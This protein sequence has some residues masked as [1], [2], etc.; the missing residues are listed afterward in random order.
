MNNYRLALAVLILVALAA[1][2]VALAQNAGDAAIVAAI[3][4]IENDSTKADLANDRSYYEKY[5]AADWTSIDSDGLVYTKADVLKEFDDPANN[6]TNSEKIT[7]MKVRVYGGDTAIAIYKVTYD[8]LVKGEH[9]SRTV[10][11]TDVWVK[12]GSDWKLVAGQGTKIAGK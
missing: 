2:S 1:G 9:R 7:D 12:M 11:S 10:L 4:K 3:T 6:K 8:A 5:L